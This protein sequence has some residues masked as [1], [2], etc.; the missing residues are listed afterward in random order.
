MTIAK[1]IL[2]LAAAG[3]AGSLYAAPDKITIATDAT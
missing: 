3:F 2:T 1:L